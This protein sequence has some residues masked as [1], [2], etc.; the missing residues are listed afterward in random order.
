MTNVRAGR[1]RRAFTLIE[2]LVVIAIIAILIG[3]LLPAVQ[4]VREAAARAKCSNN[5]KQIGLAM[6]SFHDV[7]NGLPSTRYCTPLGT[8]NRGASPVWDTISGFVY[9]LPY[10]EQDNL[11]R[12]IYSDPAMVNGTGGSPWSS[13]FIPW[14]R[15]VP[16]YQCPSESAPA[17]NGVAPR[18]YHMNVGDHYNG[19]RGAFLRQPTSGTTPDR[20]GPTI[21]GIKDGS[22]NTLLVSERVRPSSSNDIGRLGYTTST[23]PNDCKATFNYTTRTYTT[24]ASTF[25]Q[26][27]RWGDGRSFF[28]EILTILPP[29]HP[30]CT[31]NNGWDGDN[32]FYTA[33]SN[34]SGGVNAVMGDGSVR[35]IRDSIDAGNP[36]FDANTVT[37]PSPYGVWGA[38]GSRQGGEAVSNE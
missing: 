1:G 12:A 26:S 36:A 29:N 7:N 9:I 33:S 27:S 21:Q 15:V 32:G 28:G 37:G 5:L 16:T 23:I 19:S 10:L 31:R 30:S 22:S 13:A 3:L 17:Q 24:Q 34:H 25:A 38:L 35:F 18:N 2:L 6:H 14:T 20:F 8:P 4:K 11:H